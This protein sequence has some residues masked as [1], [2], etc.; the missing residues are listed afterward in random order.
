M[1]G[2]LGA[3]GFFQLPEDPVSPGDT[4]EG[5]IDLDLPAQTAH[6]L[7]QTLQL[8]AQP[9]GQHLDLAQ[10][11]LADRRDQLRQR[12]TPGAWSLLRASS[13]PTIR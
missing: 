5:N 2:Q 10:V 3:G 13:P 4:W 11:A 6:A 9:S 7:A 1:V 12:T 8:N